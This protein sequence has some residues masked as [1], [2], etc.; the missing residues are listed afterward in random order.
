MYRSRDTELMIGDIVEFGH[1]HGKEYGSADGH[2]ILWRVMDTD[3][4]MAFLVAEHFVG[5]QPYNSSAGNVGV[6]SAGAWGTFNE[7]RR[8]L[9]KD[10]RKRSFDGEDHMRMECDENND[11]ITLLT[12]EEARRYFKSDVDRRIPYAYESDMEYLDKLKGEYQNLEK[13]EKLFDKIRIAKR[14]KELERSIA[15]WYEWSGWWLRPTGYQFM[16]KYVPYV[17]GDGTMR[18]G[19]L[20]ATDDGKLEQSGMYA[21]CRLYVRPAMWIIAK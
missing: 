12:V 3:D 20:Q 14:R 18:S 4:D 11:Y 10:F 9:N 8:W 21:S 15:H 16:D 17:A 6:S 1:L 13:G 2:A 7:L 19:G 5:R